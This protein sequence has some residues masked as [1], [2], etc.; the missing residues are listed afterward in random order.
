MIRNNSTIGYINTLRKAFK[1]WFLVG[2]LIAVRFNSFTV[3][4]RENQRK[5]RWK[6]IQVLNHIVAKRIQSSGT[7]LEI[8]PDE[9]KVRFTYRNQILTFYGYQQNG[10]VQKEINNFEYYKLNFQN[11]V[12][13]DIGANSGATSIYF[14]IN[15]AKKVIAIEPMPRTYEYLKRNVEVNK[16]ESVIQCIN[17]AVSNENKEQMIQVDGNEMGL[18]AKINFSDHST[19]KAMVAVIN[20]NTLVDSLKETDIVVKMDCEGCEYCTILN[21]KPESLLKIDQIML[22][23]HNG[24]KTIFKFLKENNFAV[25]LLNKPRKSRGIIYAR[26]ESKNSI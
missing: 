26:N 1:N 24:W 13:I 12:V 3:M 25:E 14:A 6:R 18:G 7:G 5:Q 19:D 15:G 8:Y 17:G 4:L 10:W 23:Y 21:L 22:E 9:N 16:L 11:K 2:I 20:I